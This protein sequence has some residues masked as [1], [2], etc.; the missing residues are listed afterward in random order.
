MLICSSSL[1]MELGIYTSTDIQTSASGLTR[2]G[3]AFSTHSC[4]HSRT[5]SVFIVQ[6]RE[7]V[8]TL[9]VRNVSEPPKIRCSKTAGPPERQGE[10]HFI[11]LTSSWCHKCVADGFFFRIWPCLFRPHARS[12]IGYIHNDMCM[13]A[14]Q[15]LDVTIPI[16]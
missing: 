1:R 7:I 10:L 4:H 13:Y 9:V 14:F 12:N 15:L 2:E 8:C 3:V 5:S 16:E 11:A 6:S